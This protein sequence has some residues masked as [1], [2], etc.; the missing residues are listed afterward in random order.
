MDYF[1]S[2]IALTKKNRFVLIDYVND[3]CDMRLK[4]IHPDGV[5]DSIVIQF[6]EQMKQKV[7]ALKK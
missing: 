2:E 6:I 5:P 1:S 3:Q 4:S 7:L